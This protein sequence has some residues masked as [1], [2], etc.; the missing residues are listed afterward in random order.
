[1]KYYVIINGNSSLNIQGLAIESL[2]NISKPLIRT[3]REEIDGRDGD[4]ITKLGYSAYDK[5]LNIKQLERYYTPE[6]VEK[7]KNAVLSRQQIAEEIWKEDSLIQG[8]T[9]D[10]NI[11]RLRKKIKPYDKNLIT[12]EELLIKLNFADFIRRFERENMNIITFGEN[13]DYDKKIATIKERLTDYA[14]EV[15]PQQREVEPIIES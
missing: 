13:I 15:I 4:I 8:R 14:R 3:T 12:I 1:M 7:Y 2:P 11:T 10:V 5:T 9:I 6:S